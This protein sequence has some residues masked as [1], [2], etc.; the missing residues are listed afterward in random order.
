LLG[1]GAGIAVVI[2]LMIVMR[3]M[4]SSAPAAHPRDAGV[5]DAADHKGSDSA[6]H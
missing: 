5:P 6:A 1:G 3:M 2:V 4:A